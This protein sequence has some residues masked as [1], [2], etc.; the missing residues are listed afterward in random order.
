MEL[1]GSEVPRID[2]ALTWEYRKI[3]NYWN[4][5]TKYLLAYIRHY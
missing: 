1:P 3:W 5:G 4:F 2:G